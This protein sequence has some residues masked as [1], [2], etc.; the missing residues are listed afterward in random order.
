MNL[1]EQELKLRRAKDRVKKIR[2]FYSHVAIF[3]FVLVIAVIAPLFDFYFC[4][5][6]FSKDKWLNLL[7]FGPWLLG[8]CVHGLLAFGKIGFIKKWEEKK[9][10]QFLEE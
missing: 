9:L 10:K 8:L 7:G 2:G 3:C 1:Q 5:I 6:C 4:I